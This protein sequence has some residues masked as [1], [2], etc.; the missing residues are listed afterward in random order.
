MLRRLLIMWVLFYLERNR[1]VQRGREK[2]VVKTIG[3][4]NVVPSR[5]KEIDR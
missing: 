3:Y 5:Q 4:V 2:I 1:E